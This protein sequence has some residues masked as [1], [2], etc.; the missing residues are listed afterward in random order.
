MILK[1][2]MGVRVTEEE[3]LTGLDFSEHGLSAYPEFVFPEVISRGGP[4]DK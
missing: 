4:A 2:V 1:A 3:E